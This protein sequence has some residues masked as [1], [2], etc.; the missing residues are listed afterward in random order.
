MHYNN[1]KKVLL[2]N[3]SFNHIEESDFNCFGWIKQKE[4]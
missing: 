4:Q 1:E 3:S 2:L